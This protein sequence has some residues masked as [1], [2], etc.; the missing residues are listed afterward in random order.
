MNTPLILTASL[1]I[2]LSPCILSYDEY[3]VEDSLIQHEIE[4]NQVYEIETEAELELNN[5]MTDDS[6]W[7]MKSHGENLK[8][9]SEAQE[10]YLAIESWM[11]DDELWKSPV[12][13][14][15]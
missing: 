5:W 10:D 15:I 14:G 12:I 6:K 13:A 3:R 4:M 2:L 1:A 11:T 9:G 7:K 8:V